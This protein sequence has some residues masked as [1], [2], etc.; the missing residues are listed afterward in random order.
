MG[1]VIAHHRSRT[2]D[3]RLHGHMSTRRHK[4][5]ASIFIFRL[6]CSLNI[7][8]TIRWGTQK[9]KN[10]NSD[11]ETH[12]PIAGVNSE[13]PIKTNNCVLWKLYALLSHDSRLKK[14]KAHKWIFLNDLVALFGIVDWCLVVITGITIHLL[15]TGWK[16]RAD[17]PL[18]TV[19]KS[20]CAGDNRISPLLDYSSV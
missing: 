20:F 9:S 5:K 8:F 14:K 15:S 11:A 3:I 2:S 19:T 13:G 12:H 1:R 4:S 6:L 17:A 10:I 18:R 16:K 7:H